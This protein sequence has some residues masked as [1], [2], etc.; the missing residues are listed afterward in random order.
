ME[1]LITVKLVITDR[2]VT[3]AP[4]DTDRTYRQETE[5]NVLLY[6]AL[7]VGAG[8]RRRVCCLSLVSFLTATGQLTRI[9]YAAEAS[10]CFPVVS[11]P[12]NCLTSV[13]ARHI[14]IQ[15][16]SSCG[17]IAPVLLSDAVHSGGVRARG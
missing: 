6:H 17:F 10:S 14:I 7:A 3:A 9:M 4:T 12:I 2:G 5:S 8:F 15:Y 11:A 16:T 1:A 13:E